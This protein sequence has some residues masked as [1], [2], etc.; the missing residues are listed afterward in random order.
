M[1]RTH[2]HRASVDTKLVSTIGAN[3]PVYM[4]CIN[5][6]VIKVKMFWDDEMSNTDM[7]MYMKFS[8][9]TNVGLS[10]VTWQFHQF[11]VGLSNKLKCFQLLQLFFPM[12]HWLLI[13]F[14]SKLN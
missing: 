5:F 3:K 14:T 10:K 9:T 8:Q 1:E 7:S 4:Q 2:G 13:T 6:T 12:S 11:P